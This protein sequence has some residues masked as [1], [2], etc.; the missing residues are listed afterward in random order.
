MLFCTSCST[1]EF[2]VNFPCETFRMNSKFLLIYSCILIYQTGLINIYTNFF[3]AW[4]L[5]NYGLH[6]SS[7]CD[8]SVHAVQFFCLYLFFL[9]FLSKTYVA[10]FKACF[11]WIL[12]IPHWIFFNHFISSNHIRRSNYFI[13]IIRRI[14]LNTIC[15]R[16]TT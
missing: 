1:L 3:R 13:F 16:S 5:I 11:C 6:R 4:R 2:S 8:T 12:G 9:M 7:W 10:A 15:N 14:Y